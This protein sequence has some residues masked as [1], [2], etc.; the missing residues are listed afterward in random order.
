MKSKHILAIAVIV[1]LSAIPVSIVWV[2]KDK[3]EKPKKRT[4]EEMLIYRSGYLKGILNAR[5]LYG[6]H[7]ERMGQFKSTW[8]QDSTE[9]VEILKK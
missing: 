3:T 7:E 2:N 1:S 8:K 6:S 5:T 9:M 4:E